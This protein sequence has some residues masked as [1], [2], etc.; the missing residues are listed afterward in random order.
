M[1]IAGGYEKAGRQ[2]GKKEGLMADTP[3]NADNTKYVYV[4]DSDGVQYVCK[5]SDL[6]RPDKLTEE[7]K[8]KC[9]NPPGDA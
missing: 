2:P 4:K 6:K 3:K 8:A 7:E 9:M 1:T 5:L